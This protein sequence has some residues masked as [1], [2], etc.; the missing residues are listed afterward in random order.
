MVT[1]LSG[2]PSAL[3]IIPIPDGDAFRHREDFFV[4]ENLK[5]LSCSG[6]VGLSLAEPSGATQAKFYQIYHVSEKIPLYGAV[7]ELVKLCQAALFL[8]GCIDPEYVD[9]LLCDP[10]EKAINDWWVKYGM[11]LYNIEPTD[12]ILGPT[13]VAALLGTLIGARNR[14]SA[15]GAPIAKDVFDLE[16]TKRAIAYFQKAQRLPKTRRF[17]R[18]TIDRLHK[19][20]AKQAAREGWNVPRA[21][22]S[23]VAEL[24]GKGGE[25]VLDMVGRG[26]KATIADVETTDIDRFAANVKGERARWLWH[27]RA[28]KRTTRD[29]F[30]GGNG[31]GD[32]RS[33]NEQ[34]DS[35][36]RHET[37]NGRSRL[38]R[39][40]TKRLS[41]EYASDTDGEKK[42]GL[43]G[44]TKGRLKDA[45]GI[46]GHGH[47]LS[48]DS[49]TSFYDLD[50]NKSAE[51][52]AS[53][54]SLDSNGTPDRRKD[55]FHSESDFE[56]MHRKNQAE[57]LQ[58]KFTRHLTDTPIESG[59][60]PEERFF[61]R[62]DTVST[63]R[64]Q[65]EDVD[66]TRKP[67]VSR[68]FVPEVVP[69]VPPD[70]RPV[71]EAGPLLQRTQSLSHI[72]AIDVSRYH[73]RHDQAWPRHLSFSAAESSIGAHE[74]LFSTSDI[75]TPH[76]NAKQSLA[77]EQAQ[78]AHALH[79]RE[80]LAALG[81]DHVS[82]VT[83]SLTAVSDLNTLA[84]QDAEQLSALYY[85]RR[86]EYHA[87][88]EGSREIITEERNQLQESTKELETLGAKLEYEI[89]T[90]RGKVE[91][92][93]GA[94]AD[95]EK[96]VLD[97]EARVRELTR[98]RVK[99]QGWWE[100]F[101]GLRKGFEVPRKGT[102][103]PKTL[104]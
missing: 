80:T 93:E 104:S 79:L 35:L 37:N 67:S 7:I 92:V 31:D 78:A 61:G 11:D 87:L 70:D 73:T 55:F 3:T 95:F 98:E 84:S 52:F 26:E 39:Q 38:H 43:L 5:R 17:D 62:R 34:D 13:T 85:P 10:M 49:T 16:S 88:A 32:I 53:T 63:E 41:A 101:G 2:F 90:L 8:F 68:D 22:K 60:N 6:R 19:A 74:D 21:V 97:T 94:V 103:S 27:G 77:I 102:E 56:F 82:W 44:R 9:G 71:Q 59:L 64:T 12:G 66:V 76:L 4:N 24:S 30:S 99:G 29:L 42:K 65:P 72:E 58:P 40:T 83:Q 47:N 89:E 45:V 51:S 14:L 1:N 50:R 18:T 23:T 57:R 69:N 46:R 54:V 75:D 15:Y 48:K 81:R 91:D 100:W 36:H 96:Q 33:G 25:M 28:R 86:D 20:T